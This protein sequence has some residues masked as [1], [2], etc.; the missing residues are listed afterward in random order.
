[1]RS[2]LV[3]DALKTVPNRYQLCQVTSKA[4]RRFHRPA[5]RI[6]ET[7]NNVLGRVSSA[8]RRSVMAERQI[9]VAERTRRAA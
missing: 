5:T 8:E 4:T 7:T 3:Y 1:M 2:E 9:A 6:Q